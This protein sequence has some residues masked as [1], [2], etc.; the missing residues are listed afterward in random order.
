MSECGGSCACK[1]NKSDATTTTLS[2]VDKASCGTGG[3]STGT[4]TG[5]GGCC[6]G[7]GAGGGCCK[8]KVE[9]TFDPSKPLSENLKARLASTIN[10]AVFMVFIKGTP[11][12]PKCKFSK[13]LLRFLMDNNITKF[14]YFNILEDAVTREALKVYSNW[15]TYPQVYIN[16]EL[17]GGLDIVKEMHVDGDFMAKV[18]KE[19]LGKGLFPR[20]RAI[21]DQ[22]YVMLFMQ[23]TPD[24]PKTDED[25]QLVD[26]LKEYKVEFGHY[27]VTQA[28][29]VKLGL[30]QYARCTGYPQLYAGAEHVGGA[31]V[32]TT[33]HKES[34]LGALLVKPDASAPAANA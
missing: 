4:K 9:E 2:G 8:D 6:G 14:G 19:C 7:A 33:K 27:D 22:Q 11:Q 20:I 18:P 13:A 32:V 26:L 28:E 23:G 15:K 10:T 17:I 24:S 21:I 5:G 1:D 16:G 3:C 31:E 30:Q 25:K 34:K 12:E 29:D